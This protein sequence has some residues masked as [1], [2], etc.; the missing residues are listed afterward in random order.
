MSY[1]E[2]VQRLLNALGF[3]TYIRPHRHSLDPKVETLFALR[4]EFALVTFNAQGHPQGV[5]IFGAGAAAP[6]AGVELA[7]ETWHTVIALT[8][9]AV[10]FEIKAG[11]F[12]PGAAKE[13][14]AWAPEEGSEQAARYLA[15]LRKLVA[16]WPA[17]PLGA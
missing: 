14:A 1:E 17:R 8:D 13:Y 4:G 10:L 2:P 3:D 12:D 16:E 7:S 9:G 15:G 6:A 5:V 11:P